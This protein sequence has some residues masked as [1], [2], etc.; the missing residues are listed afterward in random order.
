VW[1]VPPLV[2]AIKNGQSQLLQ[3]RSSAM[4]GQMEMMMGQMVHNQA[5]QQN[6]KP[7][8]LRTCRLRP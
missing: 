3:Q 6:V 7:D 1:I 2:A 4:L 8:K 5:A